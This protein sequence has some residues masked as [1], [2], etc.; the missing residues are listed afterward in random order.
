MVG[1]FD[2]EW[3]KPIVIPADKIYVIR[4]LLIY[5]MAMEEIRREERLAKSSNS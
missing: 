3:S 5:Y 1:F 4:W 2:D